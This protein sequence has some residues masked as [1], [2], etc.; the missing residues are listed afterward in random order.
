M[1]RENGAFFITVL[2][3]I[4]HCNSERKSFSVLAVVPSFPAYGKH[5]RN[6]KL[7]LNKH[8]FYPTVC[9]TRKPINTDEYCLSNLKTL[10][11]E[12]IKRSH[13]SPCVGA[14]VVPFQPDVIGTL[15]WIV[16]IDEQI[17]PPVAVPYR[18]KCD[19]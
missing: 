5:S 10:T 1:P 13:L 4:K 18:V 3:H 11:V 7:H 19:A 14:S 16:A 12:V 6:V 15:V 9:F 17:P 2:C 8:R